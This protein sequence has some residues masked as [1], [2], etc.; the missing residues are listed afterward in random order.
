VGKVDA[1][2]LPTAD[3]IVARYRS[4]LGSEQQ[5]A[6]Q[7]KRVSRGTV[8]R[9]NGRVDPVSAPFTLTQELP[10]KADLQ[11]ELSYPPDAEREVVGQFFRLSKAPDAK[12]EATVTG[13]AEV[14]GHE[15]YV[16]EIKGE[17]WYFDVKSGLLLRRHREIT[18]P[19]GVLPEEF[20]FDDYRSVS[21][22]K[23]PFFMQWSRADYQVTHRFTE[24]SAV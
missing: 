15:A 8:T 21:G 24:V 10:G 4:A 5:I 9:W 12:L 2:K 19:L 6:A 13:K 16:V 23:V 3:E 14:R 22:V 18:T 11:T 17:R 20:D 1:P 7:H